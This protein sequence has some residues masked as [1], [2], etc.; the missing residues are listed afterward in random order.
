MINLIIKIKDYENDPMTVIMYSNNKIQKKKHKQKC[1]QPWMTKGILRATKDKSKL[2][3][4]YIKNPTAS[5]KT[6]FIQYRNLFKSLK[7]KTIKNYYAM[8]FSKY[9]N[10]IKKTWDTIK[11][12]INSEP[13]EMGIESLL[14]N[15]EI[16]TD[17][18]TIASALN[19]YFT[20]IAQNLKANISPTTSSYSDY[21]GTPEP[22]SLAWIPTFPAEI[23]SLSSSLNPSKSIGPD[24]LDPSIIRTN[25]SIIINPLAQIFNSSLETGIV[26][27][28]MKQAVV[29]PIFKQGN[30]EDIGNYRPISISP[31]FSKLL[32]K[33]V[34]QRLADYVTKKNIIHS[35][36]HGFRSGYSTVLP[37]ISI[38]DKI[39][40]AIDNN[41][42]SVGIFLDLSKAFDTVDH[43]IL[44]KN[45]LIME[46]VVRRFF[47]LQIIY[48]I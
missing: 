18:E 10:D 40:Q 37:L 14:I 48:L 34:H 24:H 4:S 12:I 27:D 41:E 11:D 31:F 5:N 43:E 8:E 29:I 16:T 36:Q 45:L 47:G 19:T 44:I 15:G 9:Y 33:V 38:Q 2:Y 22:S 23:M 46:F 39:T 13:Q 28:K 30:R 6:K 25:L 42:F 1:N 35:T 20:G 32:E 3:L 26:P 7:N 17:K 21:L